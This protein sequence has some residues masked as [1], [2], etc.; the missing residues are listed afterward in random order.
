MFGRM[1]FLLNYFIYSH[2]STKNVGFKNGQ[3]ELS[4]QF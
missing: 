4:F 3:F 1:D 2:L